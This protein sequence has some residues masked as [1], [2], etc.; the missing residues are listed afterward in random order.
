MAQ[1]YSQKDFV[2]TYEEILSIVEASVPSTV[3][4]PRISTEADPG[5]VILKLLAMYEDR[6]NYRFDLSLAQG[7]PDS[8]SDRQL[9]YDLFETL[10]YL[11]RQARAATGTIELLPIE[12]GWT[13]T[14][15]KSGII[16]PRFT[17]LTDASKKLSFFTT[18]ETIV[19]PYGLNP[20]DKSIF[21][22]KAFIVPVQAGEPFQITKDG[23]SYFTLKDIDEQ[24]RL[25]LGKTELAQ[26]GVYVF[27]RTVSALDNTTEILTDDWNYVDFA[28]LK[29][30]GKWYM[31]QTASTGEVY[32]QFPSNFEQLIGSSQLV[33]YATYTTGSASN[34]AANSIVSFENAEEF[35][36][37]ITI[38]QPSAF[39]TGQD[40]ESIEQAK[41]NYYATKD[42]CNTLVSDSD[43]LTALKYL[44]CS[45]EKEDLEGYFPSKGSRYFSN[46][47]IESAKDRRTQ[48]RTSYKGVNYTLYVPDKTKPSTELDI[49]GLQYPESVD[50]AES[51]SYISSFKKV[52]DNLPVI[53]SDIQQQLQDSTSIDI[54]VENENITIKR[55][56][57]VVVPQIV[58]R[59]SN[60][61]ITGA[62]ELKKSIQKYFYSTY[63]SGNL[64]PG[65]ALDFQRIIDDIKQLSP[66]ILSV[67]MSEFEY[68][69][70]TTV[71]AVDGV[72]KSTQITNSTTTIK[73]T[74]ADTET[75]DDIVAKT[76]LAGHVPLFDYYNRQNTL[77]KQTIAYTV[78]AGGSSSDETSSDFVPKLPVPLNVERADPAD[79]SSGSSFAFIGKGD[80]V[81]PTIAATSGIN[82]DEVSSLNETQVM[83]V[84]SGQYKP[85]EDNSPASYIG[86]ALTTSNQVLQIRHPVRTAVENYGGGYKYKFT[87]TQIVPAQDIAN[88]QEK[89]IE[90]TKQTILLPGTKVN[91]NS[92]LYLDDSS[93]TIPEDRYN[94]ET[95]K[96]IKTFTIDAG[97]LIL[98]TNEKSLLMAGTTIAYGSTVDG[99]LFTPDDVP[100]EEEYCIKNGESLVIT[101]SS[102]PNTIVAQFKSGDYIS[103]SGFALNQTPVEGSIL[104][105]TQVI[106]KLQE[107][108]TTIPANEFLYFLSLNKD[109]GDITITKDSPL[110]LDEK[111]YLLYT[112]RS[113][114]EY[115]TLG[116]GTL[117]KVV[118]EDV[119]TLKNTPISSLDNISKS[120]FTLLQSSLIVQPY[121]IST[122]LKGSYVVCTPL[123]G[124][125]ANKQ[126]NVDFLN[127]W[128]SFSDNALLR[129]YNDCLDYD[130][131]TK[132]K[133]AMEFKDNPSYQVRLAVSIESDELG[134]ATIKYPASITLKVGGTESKIAPSK[135]QSAFIV[136]S[137]PFSGVFA[138]SK[139]IENTA[140]ETL[141]FPSGVTGV[142][143]KANV[144]GSDNENFLNSR[145]KYYVD[146][147]DIEII[148][149][150]LSSDSGLVDYKKDTIFSTT[151]AVPTDVTAVQNNN[152]YILMNGY[153]TFPK[154]LA[155][156]YM[157]RL[158]TVFVQN[159]SAEK[160]ETSDFTSS[161]YPAKI[162]LYENAA[163][164]T[165]TVAAAPV[166]LT[167]KKGTETTN[168]TIILSV[169]TDTTAT[170]LSIYFKDANVNFNE[171]KGVRIHLGD[172]S[173]IT[174][175][176]S[177]SGYQDKTDIFGSKVF[178]RLTEL[179][180][181]HKFNW[182]STP[183]EQISEPLVGKNYFNPVHPYNK[184]TFPYLSVQL[185]KIQI[186]P[187][188]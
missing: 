43:F 113:V 68:T 137:V 71:K 131:V 146:G 46:V 115:L 39:Y 106:S 167:C 177:E 188:R 69:P 95:H 28:I 105:S 97:K 50:L 169:P 1:N 27:T 175:F 83:G 111:E 112:D 99:I 42:I 133:L 154:R 73:D 14:G 152:K 88:K 79:T 81:N 24:G 36:N 132:E 180:T 70:Y 178:K 29:S 125:S 170:D 144:L 139:G 31:V 168:F 114:S 30:Q 38:N 40:S 108:E 107:T 186:L 118:D 62:A 21:S 56:L 53:R 148:P 150:N 103:V 32:I 184:Y 157:L 25:Y 84:N 145:V 63:S 181:E 126:P 122:F 66:N 26:N 54:D 2:S 22:S 120:S 15:D 102:E 182:I 58:I 171:L 9:A 87:R 92:V 127:N 45:L 44:V 172:L 82:P 185:D 174:G 101:K 57:N 173:Y 121:E 155:K 60:Y 7:Y 55:I 35:R 3:W 52:T 159:L 109:P 149:D 72:E 18:K 19:A 47:L 128:C 179:D 33:V 130:D 61:T 136:S 138:A 129:V 142:V 117:I 11:M 123:G 10:G 124:F 67:S 37:F 163:S 104:L 162:A 116:P 77:T 76:V 98:S 89:G 91:E 90:I 16:I 119:I 156:D 8:V 153:I 64:V 12:N 93:D 59:I 75:A 161:H 85:P 141:L 176:S 51:T 96:V 6:Y 94:K 17:K 158:T 48:V 4:S 65:Q 151:L 164:F 143:A 49:L 110:M 187:E 86:F 23:Y 5:V 183:T 74:V 34:I 78:L 166:E 13:N 140:S 160:E 134:V 80:N 41:A 100:Q 20:D 135:D 165:S 147:A